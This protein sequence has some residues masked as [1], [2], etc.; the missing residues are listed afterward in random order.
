MSMRWIVCLSIAAG[1]HLAAA[2]PKTP[3]P[4]AA[5]APATVAPAASTDAPASATAAALAPSPA[6]AKVAPTELRIAGKEGA[7]QAYLWR[8]DGP[9]PFPAIVYNHGSERDPW[10]GSHGPV[11][12]FFAKNGYVVLFPYRR[13][14]GKSEGTHWSDRVDKLPD[15]Q[16][17]QGTIDALVDENDDVVAAVEWLRKQTYVDGRAVSVAGCSFGGIESLLTAARPIGLHAVVDFAGG[18][19]SWQAN[20]PLRERML[21]AAEAATVPVFFVQAANDFDTTP[22]SALSEAMRTKNKPYRVQI[23]PAFGASHQVGHS[24]CI[25]GS[26]AWGPAVLDFLKNRR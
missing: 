3:T 4:P 18:A 10:V 8:P 26:D 1:C 24:F 13:G 21:Q 11:G 15:A 22:S 20:G 7:M 12:L 6:P 16:Q 19:M 25:R 9:G 14:A 17:Y 23:F 5:P 2:S